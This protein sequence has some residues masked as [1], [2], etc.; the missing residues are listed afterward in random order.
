MAFKA[1]KIDHTKRSSLVDPIEIFDS[2]TLR[3]SVNNLW[4]PQSK[5]LAEWHEVRSLQDVSIEMNTGGGKTLV[6]LLVSLSLAREL[7]RMVLFVS[8][9]IQLIQQTAEKARECSIEVAT[10]YDGHWSNEQVA[11]SATGPCLTTHAALFNGKSIFHRQDLG[12]VVLDDAHA[13]GGIIRDCFTLKIPRTHNLYKEVA[14]LFRPYF[15]R[16]S[17]ELTFDE[18]ITGGTREMLFVPLFESSKQAGVIQKKILESGLTE[19]K[20]VK[21]A[22]AHLKDRLD[23]S[24]IL[25]NNNGLEIAPA[26]VPT[27][28]TPLFQKGA[29]RVYLTATLPSPIEFHRTFGVVPHPVKPTGRSGE[30]QR[31]FLAAEGDTDEKQQ[32]SAKALL[33][34]HK[35]LILTPST[36]AASEWADCAEQFDQDDDNDR[37]EEFKAAEP[38]EKLVLAARYDGIDLPGDACRIL[39]LDGLPRGE[40]LLTKYIN[41]SLRIET[42]R[43]ATTAIRVVQAVGRIFRSNTDHG[44]VILVGSS[45]QRWLSTPFNRAF[46]PAL[47]QKQLDLAA[48]IA[49]KIDAGDFTAEDVLNDLLAGG[50]E[51]DEFYSENIGKFASKPAKSPPDWLTGAI[52]TERAAHHAMWQGDYATAAALYAKGAQ[53]TEA[54]D[55]DLA[56]WN[57]HFEGFCFERSGRPELA[58]AAYVSA[59]ARRVSLGRPKQIGAA[60]P[61]I[62]AGAAGTQA[63]RI[64]QLCNKKAAQTLARAQALPGELVFGSSSGRIEQAVLDLGKLLGLDSSR[65]DAELNTGPDILWLSEDEAVGHAFEAK[66]DKLATSQY[67]K[68]EVGQAHDHRQWIKNN[69]RK[70]TV[71]LSWLGRTLPVSPDSSPDEDLT[72]FELG[73]IANLAA[74]VRQ[75]YEAM[76]VEA[77]DADAVQAWLTHSG[78]VFPACVHALP[79]RRAVDLK[80]SDDT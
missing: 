30:A 62:L 5:A 66:T 77:V 76:L 16:S 28:Q 70:R 72:V 18:V 55:P 56:A 51:W 80:S 40:A 38:P 4:T 19:T 29:R 71:G 74:R 39:V 10:Y 79:M 57:R 8:P 54:N 60:K 37:I 9:T 17:L 46:L 45:I 78:L 36:P 43:A 14:E 59:A 53:A 25:F 48:E 68:S 35:A 63:A 31:V 58:E 61:R 65:P 64:A 42:V 49:E 1:F 41:E 6:G 52:Q 13:A 67:N 24:V 21:F 44:A 3:G 73:S 26:C 12:A 20:E 69:H 47:L 34:D 75:L 50:K 27:E 2:L 22:W 7:D 11:T 33:I 32:A 15:R 23:R